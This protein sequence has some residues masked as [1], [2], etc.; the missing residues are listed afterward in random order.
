M[1]KTPMCVQ[2]IIKYQFSYMLV[3]KPVNEITISRAP[4]LRSS[5]GRKCLI[6][7]SLISATMMSLV[8][9]DGVIIFEMNEYSY[10]LPCNKSW[11]TMSNKLYYVHISI[12]S[13]GRRYLIFL[14]HLSTDIRNYVETLVACVQH[15]WWRPTNIFPGFNRSTSATTSPDK[16]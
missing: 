9:Q 7:Y 13:C 11:R 1:G 12:N 6:A 14:R 3:Y 4:N 15:I 10:Q 8:I 2:H 5:P 16:K